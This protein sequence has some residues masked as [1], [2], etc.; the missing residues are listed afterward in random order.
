MS[1]NQYILVQAGGSPQ[2][3]WAPPFRG[4]KSS[5]HQGKQPRTNLRYA[6]LVALGLVFM[7]L[8]LVTSAGAASADKASADLGKQIYMRECASCHGPEGD[9]NGPGAYILSQRPRNLQLGVFKLRSTLTG[10]NPTDDDLFNTIT[11]GIAGATGAMMPSFASFPEK[12]RWALVAF[13]KHLSGIEE[14]GKPILVPD[15]P[16]TVDMAMGQKVYG[17]LQCGE[18]HGDQGRGDGPSAL[19]LKD[20]Q[21][22][23]IWVPDL[24]SRR[25]KGGAEPQ[26]I[27]KRIAT[28]IDGTPMPSYAT[29]ANS[30]EIWALTM[31]VLSLSDEQKK[32]N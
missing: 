19:T 16:S 9:G 32:P 14:A 30:E 20:A 21:K 2:A 26:D 13:V 23:R 31:Y 12:D 18:C 10:E 22:R 15:P 1:Q 28:G 5:E 24:T 4:L 29:K 6:G 27:Y 8:A 25:Y 7:C 11:R 3:V 17:R